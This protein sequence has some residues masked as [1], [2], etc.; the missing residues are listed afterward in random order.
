VAKTRA[1]LRAL[2]AGAGSFALAAVPAGGGT[3]ARLTVP[4]HERTAE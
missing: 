1:R 4:W 3:E 2:Y